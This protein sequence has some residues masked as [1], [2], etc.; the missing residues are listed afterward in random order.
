[1]TQIVQIDKFGRILIPKSVREKMGFKPEQSLELEDNEGKITLRPALS[2]KVELRD[3]MY[4][5]TGFDPLEIPIEKLVDDARTDR[6][7]MLVSGS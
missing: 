2:G 5:W 7:E 4:V 6:S 3:G 1:M